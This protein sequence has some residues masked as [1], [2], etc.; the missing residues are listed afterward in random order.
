MG[1]GILTGQVAPPPERYDLREDLAAWAEAIRGVRDNPLVT[2][3]RLAE[4]RRLARIPRWRRNLPLLLIAGGLG[5]LVFY[6]ASSNWTG[7]GYP[8]YA[9]YTIGALFC[10]IALAL[11]LLMQ[12]VFQ[13]VTGA[14]GVLGRY[15][16]RPSHLC[17]DDFT[18]LSSLSDH[19]IVVGAVGV[20]LPPLLWRLVILGV[21]LITTPLWMLWLPDGGTGFVNRY[22]YYSSGPM[23][24]DTSAYTYPFWLAAVFAYCLLLALQI[25][26]TGYFSG[27]NLLLYFICLG[28]GLRVESIAALA[29][30]GT[31]IGQ[32][33]YPLV[34]TIIPASLFGIGNFTTDT[35][36][37]FTA[38]LLLLC[39]LVYLPA[40]LG[41][42]MGWARRSPAVRVAA[43]LGNPL[44]WPVLLLISFWVLYPLLQVCT[45]L[46]QVTS[47]QF[48]EYTLMQNALLGNLTALGSG[49][50]IAPVF[51]FDPYMLLDS[52]GSTWSNFE[53][54]LFDS[55]PGWQLTL[56]LFTT[57]QLI[58][59]SI[60]AR[61]ARE[62]VRARRS[63][64][65]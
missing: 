57:M 47:P 42:V 15:H 23:A 45:P 27:I 22:A 38:P 26:F 48:D 46:F 11:G 10:A 33:A 37:I 12:G 8:R 14:L 39:L 64:G 18:C 62:A 40:V 43:A 29:A 19:E 61:F 44:L 55:L 58:A 41:L 3:L 7:L 54:T 65:G 56:A 52:M 34:S 25:I 13:A 63:R 17:L 35:T 50:L 36:A 1:H 4:R 32:L 28:R 2:H 30:M 53:E 31:V 51:I 9:M 59:M 60:L 24:A 16:K 21:G 6:W 5:L 49:A 20:L